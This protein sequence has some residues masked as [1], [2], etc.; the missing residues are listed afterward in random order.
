MC[1]PARRGRTCA[2]CHAA[3]SNSRRRGLREDAAFR[4]W[5][6]AKK[7]AAGSALPVSVGVEQIRALLPLDGLCPVLGIPL[8]PG[9]G[10]SNDSSPTLDRLNPAWGYEVGNLAVISMRANRIKGD[11]TAVELERVAA[12]MRRK[13]LD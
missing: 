2:S 4:L 10:M 5:E 13:G 7:R 1:A 12:W 9:R 6:G 3:R 11:C 8:V